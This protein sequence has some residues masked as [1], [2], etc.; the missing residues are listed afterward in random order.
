MIHR[1]LDLAYQATL[2]GK[3]LRE[4]QIVAIGDQVV[5]MMMGGEYQVNDLPTEENGEVVL[6]FLVTI[7]ISDS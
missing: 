4:D 5:R 3:D 7:S 2:L 1:Y 6:T